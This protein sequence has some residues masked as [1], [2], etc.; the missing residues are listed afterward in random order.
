LAVL[1]GVFTN[2]VF[3]FIRVSVLF[4]AVAAAG[5]SLADYSAAEMSTYVW[6]GQALPRRSD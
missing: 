4:A 6:L 1:A 5:G 2:A 3:G